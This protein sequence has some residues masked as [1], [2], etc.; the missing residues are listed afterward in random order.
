MHAQGQV[1]AFVAG[2]GHFAG[3]RLDFVAQRGNGFDHAGA[4]AIRAG[5]AEHA[6]ESLLGALAGDAHQAKFVEGQRFRRRFIFFEG[7]LQ[8]EQN[9]VA[10][11]ALFHVDEVDHDDAAQIAQTNLAHDFLHRFQIGFDD[12]VFEAR[13]TFADEFAGVDVDGHQRFGVVD[14]DVAAGLQPHFGAQGFV[15]FVLN[16]ELFEDG[17][18]LGV[19]LDAADQ[20]GL[21]A[22][23]E[24]NDLAEFFFAIDPD[25]GEIVADVIAQDAFDE[26]QIA[27]EQRRS[28]ALLAALLDFV[29]GGAEEFDVGANF[30][31]GGATSRG[32]HDEAA[33]IAAAGFANE[34]SQARAIIGAGDFARDADV[35]DGGHVHEEAARQS[36]VTGDARAFFAE[37]LLGDLDDYILTSLEHFGNELRA[38]RRAMMASLVPAIVTRAAWPAGP[39]LE[40]LAGASASAAFR[41]ATTIV[42]ASSTAVWTA[43]AIIAAAI[44]STAT[45]GALETL[46]RL[47][48]DAR[49]GARKFCARR[50]HAAGAAR[51]PG[52]ARQQDDV[53]LGDGRR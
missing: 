26:I 6:L 23:D 44:T 51:S 47:A 33:G 37:R 46:A 10:V 41:T 13:G 40:T 25:G 4:G 17:R 2:H 43:T 34:A 53:V 8:R 39:A 49:G 48:A 38:A 29:P 52:F 24:F 14:D 30:F 21:E 42:G 32:A 36:D 19:Q 28:F 15:E 9:F 20:L 50:R 7:L 1:G 45:E 18:F 35:I 5:L 3:F 31:V 11:A 27:M 16:A 12:G 22:A